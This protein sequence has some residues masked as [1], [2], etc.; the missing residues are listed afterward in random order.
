MAR[1]RRAIQ[2]IGLIVITLA[3]WGCARQAAISLS[4][5]DAIYYQSAE[6]QAAAIRRGDITSTQLLDLYLARIKRYNAKINAV[7][8]LDEKGARARAAEADRALAQGKPWGPLHGLPMTV[9]DVYDVKGM[10]NTSGSPEFKDHRP[11]HNAI[12][13]Q[14]LVDAG[15]IVFGKTNTPA[16][17]ADYQTYNQLFGVTNN[18]WDLSRTPGGSSG[19]AAAALAMGFTPVGTGERHRGLPARAGQLYRGLWP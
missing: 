4:G 11:Q 5:P 3:G 18:P 13:V 10:A 15:A 7:V 16:R 2:V 1:N 14:R 8:A 6:R 19:G 12:A 17:G 9:K